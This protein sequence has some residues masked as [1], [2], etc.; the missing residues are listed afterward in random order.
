MAHGDVDTI[1][2]DGQWVNRVDGDPERSASFSS[3]DEAVE[4]G[5]ELAAQLGSVHRVHDAPA[6]GDITDEQS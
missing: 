6:T 3:R 1:D 5:R 4:A 2:K